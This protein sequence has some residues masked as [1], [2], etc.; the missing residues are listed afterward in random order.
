LENE[1]PQLDAS[2]VGRRL[3]L[4]RQTAGM[5]QVELAQRI[6]VIPR[7]I[8]NYEAGRIPWR[9]LSKLVTTLEVSKEW[10]LYGNDV[11]SV[12]DDEVLQRLERIE[13]LLSDILARLEAQQQTSGAN[14]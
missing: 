11:Q 8:Q 13:R 5:T 12:G 2:A 3:A 9:L 14:T 6:G 10:L 1:T 4:A 7:S